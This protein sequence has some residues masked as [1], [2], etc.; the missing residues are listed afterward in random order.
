MV[1]VDGTDVSIEWD[2]RLG[3][4]GQYPKAGDYHRGKV[5]VSGGMMLRQEQVTVMHELMHHLW[6]R[7]QLSN[8]LSSNTEELVL[9]TLD[10][11]IVQMLRDNPEL[12]S[13]LTEER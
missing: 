9:A 11:W 3:R 8:F 7:T 6:E 1:S 13:F 10:S 4:I 12:V 2:A 5:R